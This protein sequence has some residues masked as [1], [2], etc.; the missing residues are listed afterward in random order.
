MTDAR[1]A[2]VKAHAAART[3]LDSAARAAARAAGHSAGTA[4]MRGHARVAAAYAIAATASA[5][6]NQ[7]EEAIEAEKKWQIERLAPTART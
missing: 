4:H 1:A 5:F 2:A 3:C 7:M 6:P